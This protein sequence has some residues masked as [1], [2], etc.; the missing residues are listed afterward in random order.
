MVVGINNIVF[1]CQLYTVFTLFY[2]ALLCSKPFLPHDSFCNLLLPSL[3]PTV[4]HTYIVL[5]SMCFWLFLVCVFFNRLYI[6]VRNTFFVLHF[7]KFFCYIDVIEKHRKRK[8]ELQK[9]DA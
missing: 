5:S 9:N 1:D 4:N 3:S 8:K 7:F 2:D 6:P